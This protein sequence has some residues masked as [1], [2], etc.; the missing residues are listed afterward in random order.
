MDVRG[1]LRVTNHLN[2]IKG[3]I[4]KRPFRFLN[5]SPGHPSF[6]FFFNTIHLV[7][8]LSKSKIFWNKMNT[9][10]VRKIKKITTKEPYVRFS[11]RDHYFLTAQTDSTMWIPNPNSICRSELARQKATP[12]E[13]LML[14]LLRPL[15]SLEKLKSVKKSCGTKTKKK[16]QNFFF[17]SLQTYGQTSSGYYRPYMGL[18]QT[19]YQ[20]AARWI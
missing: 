12:C 2:E 13:E 10:S 9:K 1:S 15:R 5:S 14:V 17:S 16:K 4:K 20:D 11:L 7:F 19:L 6:F 18:I 8:V 3:P